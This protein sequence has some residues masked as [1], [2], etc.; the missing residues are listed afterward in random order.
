MDDKEIHLL[1]T[2]S[3]P[4][5]LESKV[6]AVSPRLVVHAHT[7]RNTELLPEDVLDKVEILYT[8]DTLPDPDLVPNLRWIQLHYAGVDHVLEHPLLNADILVTTMSGASAPQMAEFVLAQML[9][10]GHHLIS[11][12]SDP[13]KIRWAEDRYR[14]YQPI[15]LRGSTVGIVGYGSI[16]RE[17]ARLCHAFGVSVLAIKRDLK[18]LD[19]EEYIVEGLG[20]PAAEI[21]D[22]IYPPEAIRS[23]VALCDFVVITLPLTSTTRGTFDKSVLEAMKSDAYLIDVSRG[24]ILDHG[25]L[26]EVLNDGAI[27][28]AALDV[29]PIEPLPESSPLWRMPNVIL[30]PHIAGASDHYLERA[31]DLFVTNLNR[32]IVDGPLLNL[33]D[34][35]TG[36]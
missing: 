9:A 17:V 28:G 7:T 30:S 18:R 4:D 31:V 14:R 1:N 23:M 13:P 33:Y 16:G 11:Y 24:G 5:I 8:I 34:P 21:P 22:R 2:V 6:T 26:V 32:Y 10:L 19:D 35:K 12:T 15:E 36:Y 29:Y 20:D 27:A 3:F 25:A